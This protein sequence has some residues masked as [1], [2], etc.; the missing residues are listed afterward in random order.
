MWTHHQEQ[1]SQFD[2]IGFILFQNDCHQLTQLSS[3][4]PVSLPA[5]L[6]EAQEELPEADQEQGIP[7]TQGYR[8][9]SRKQEESF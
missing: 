6:Q 2:R 3:Q 9:C 5:G 8:A 1:D 4:A 7:E